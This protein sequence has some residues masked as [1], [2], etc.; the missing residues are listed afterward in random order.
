MVDRVLTAAPTPTQY[1]VLRA[2][3]VQ[4][5]AA[6]NAPLANL[7]ASESEAVLAKSNRR[8][9]CSAPVTSRLMAYRAIDER[10]KAAGAALELLYSLAEAE[11]NRDILSRSI[12]QLDGAVA[13]LDRLKQSGLKMP[14]DRTALERQKLDWLDQHIQLNAA[15]AKMQGQLQ[16]LCGFDIDT[17]A[18]IW[19][20]T[21]LAVTVGAIDAQ[22]AISD[23]LA[24]RADLGA[25]KM[26]GGSLSADTLPA[27]QTGMQGLGAGLGTSMVANRLIG[28]DSGSEGEL[29]SRQSQLNDA[30]RELER[31]I[32]RE[33]AEGVQA[34]DARLRGIAVAKERCDVWQ[35]RLAQMKGRREADG[36][37]TFDLNAVEFE[38][39]RAE[40]D[41]LHRVV[42]WKIAQAKLRQA[43]GLLAVDCGYRM[44]D[45]CGQ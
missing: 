44:P 4:C 39:L 5:L 33:V 25:I 43:Q 35:Q 31:T 7:Y 32:S 12:Q 26:L 23:G 6:A 16:Q 21:D 17:N 15:V 18:P 42:A 28:R 22:A 8:T 20:Q 9:R 13:N 11:A 37:T 10:N 34:V 40:G 41:R 36:V 14:L 3:E 24:N 45:Q 19:P 1:R 30:Q 29:Q 38:I 27:I 2:E